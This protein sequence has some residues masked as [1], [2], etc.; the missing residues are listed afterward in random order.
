MSS[1]ERAEAHT[2]SRKLGAPSSQPLNLKQPILQH[3]SL[4]L[5][6]VVRCQLHHVRWDLWNLTNPWQWNLA[7]KRPL[8]CVLSLLKQRLL[9]GRA[10]W[11][12]KDSRPWDAWSTL[13]WG[14][15]L[16]NKRWSCVG[17]KDG[18]WMKKGEK[19]RERWICCRSQRSWTHAL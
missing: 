9:C 1:E 6:A 7:Q 18:R 19:S 14:G 17:E 16:I 15:K 11:I 12:S 5:S 13:G 8:H 2:L 3:T 10:T 4:F